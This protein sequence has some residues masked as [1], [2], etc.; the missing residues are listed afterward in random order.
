[1]N[2]LLR[3]VLLVLGLAIVLTA[4]ALALVFTPPKPA[5]VVAQERT[6][7]I[8]VAARPVLAGSRIEKAD[9]GWQEINRAVVP[10]GA[11]ER[12]GNGAI[13]VVGAI[14]LRNLAA[15]EAVSDT[16]YA[17]APAAVTL[18]ASLNPG[19]RAVTITAD[20]AHTAAGMLL[21]N[22]RI[23]LLLASPSGQ[24][25]SVAVNLPFA[26]SGGGTALG[27][28]AMTITNVRVIAINGAMQPKDGGAA[29]MDHGADAGGTLTLE[30]RPDQVAPILTAATAGQ[31]AVAAR[32][33]FDT[34]GP[35]ALA[36]KVAA[37]TVPAG[38]VA[39]AA[40][41]AASPAPAPAPRRVRKPGMGNPGIG[42]PGA[43]AGNGAA[44]III[45]GGGSQRA[46]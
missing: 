34:A 41:A 15:G 44:V 4:G 40:A 23:D 30:V 18:A 32:S 6:A 22:D 19:W 36:D 24:S 37:T 26:K 35:R 38:A 9:I 12:G 27:T 29:V 43:S 5:A 16:A 17:K 20:V 46:Q 7:V 10:A 39:G 3:N 25:T 13:D 1:M 45:R 21:P 31:L 33:R 28:A 42:N 8:M 14:A 2:R 11:I